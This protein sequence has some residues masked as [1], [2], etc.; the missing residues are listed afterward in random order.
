MSTP[1]IAAKKGDIAK[2]V[3]MP[4]DPLRAKFIAETYFDN[5]VLV[6]SV[7]GMLC[8]RGTYKGKPV[9]AMGSG[10]GMPSIGIYSYEL[11]TSY[12]VDRII[13]VGSCGGHS[14]DLKLFD[15]LL[16]KDAYADST[17]A[18]MQSGY[19]GSVTEADPGL[20]EKL[21]A[22]AQKLSVPLIEG[23]TYSSDVFY[24]QPAEEG[25]RPRWQI[26]LE[27]HDCL[28]VEMESFALFHNARITGKEG[29][30]LLTVS[31]LIFDFQETTAEEREK[32]FT[33]MM[34]VAL[35]IL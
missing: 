20:N 32:S 22:S 15:V 18:R 26:A 23:R 24:Y 34:E 16:I 6:N 29:A 14:K 21:R 7:R 28:V 33:Q 27:D 12:D 5:P 4:G 17:Y 2:T 8:Y 30:T 10:M 13:R 19:E 3:L 31:D 35:G 25:D 1:H 11:F 9:S